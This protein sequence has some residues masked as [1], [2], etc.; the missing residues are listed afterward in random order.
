MKRIIILSA[1]VLALS[2]TTAKAVGQNYYVGDYFYTELAPYGS[3][4]EIDYGVVVWKPTIMHVSWLPYRMGRW[5]WTYDGWYWDSYE[6]F[7]Y[8][9]YHYGRWFYDDYYGWLWYPDYE[10]APAWVEWRYSNDYIGW[11]PLHPYATFSITF[12]IRFTKSY[13]TPYHHWHFISFNHFC[14]P[15]PYNYYV[16][17]NYRYRIYKTT[18]YRTNYVYHNGRIQNRGVDVNYIRV[19]SNQ[20]IRQRDIIR[21]HDKRDLSRKGDE[22]KIRTLEI[23]REDLVRNDLK[24]MEIQRDKRRTDLDHTKIEVGKRERTNTNV[25]KERNVKLEKRNDVKI[26][27]DDKKQDIQK[28]N[29]TREIKTNDVKRKEDVKINRDQNNNTTKKK[30]VKTSVID[31]NRKTSDRKNTIIKKNVVKETN[32]KRFETKV[33]KQNTQVKKN[34]RSQQNVR[35]E[36]RVNKNNMNEKKNITR[37]DPPVKRN[38][39]KVTK[40]KSKVQTNRT[41]VKDKNGER[42]KR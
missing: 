5:V 39:T 35:T 25:N 29:R 23:K 9:T 32:D 14:N 33:K 20:E 24:R 31:Q 38:E 21:V 36:V 4:I 27:R 40:N 10:W 16:A 15:Y 41:M 28:D 11:A 34:V 7:G 8:I 42:R 6:P 17:P 19:R 26:T 12:G 30:D 13:Y 2:F 1:F 3:W 22:N 37:N 18:K